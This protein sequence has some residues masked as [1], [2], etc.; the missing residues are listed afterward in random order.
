MGLPMLPD[1]AVD[2]DKST[3][4]T[5]LIPLVAPESVVGGRG[6]IFGCARPVVLTESQQVRLWDSDDPSA[7]RGWS[8]PPRD[9][10]RPY[11]E[12]VG[13]GVADAE[14][15]RGDGVVA[16]CAR[17][18]SSSLPLIIIGW[19]VVVILAVLMVALGI[20]LAAR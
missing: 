9:P 17:W 19:A 8:Q 15:Q 13:A 4:I 6:A 18:Q 10:F 12:F 3:T 2:D 20:A 16:N 1:M 7:L 5:D 11:G 14:S